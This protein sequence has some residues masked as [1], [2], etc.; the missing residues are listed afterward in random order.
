MKTLK[1]VLLS[2]SLVSLAACSSNPHKAEEI[3]TEMEKKNRV[4]GDTKVGVKDGNMVVQ[5]KALIAEELRDLQIEVFTLED[6]VFGN[7]KYNS[8]GLYGLLKKCRLEL[9]KKT[10]GGTGKLMWT[11]PMDRVTDKEEDL[12]LGIDE[13]GDLVALEEEFL[14]DRMKR[15][16]GYKRTL[17]K[18]RSEYQD[19]LEICEAELRSR[20]H[21]RDQAKN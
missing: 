17:L 3:E 9:S 8:E 14:R 7:S 10:N 11:E 16:K 18:R 20:K 4:I 19:K 5:R 15:F 6:R 21:D 1:A 13:K 2:I 12:K